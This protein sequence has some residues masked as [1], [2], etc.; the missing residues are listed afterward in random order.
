MHRDAE[1]EVVG[2]RLPAGQRGDLRRGI[3]RGHLR[4]IATT[5]YAV[6]PFPRP[7]RPIDI[8]FVATILS[9]R[10]SV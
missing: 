4:D 1:E 6:R 7:V 9:Y 2:R 10:H 3:E 5:R 8:L